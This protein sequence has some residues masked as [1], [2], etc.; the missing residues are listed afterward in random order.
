MGSLPPAATRCAAKD[1]WTGARGEQSG[2][3]VA[4]RVAAHGV[5]LLSLTDCIDSASTKH[6]KYNANR[7]HERRRRAQL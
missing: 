4:A 6:S 2:G 5:A 1:L 3:R 7:T